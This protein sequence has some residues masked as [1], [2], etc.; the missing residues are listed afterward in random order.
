M[1]GRRPSRRDVRDTIITGTL[2]A[3]PVMGLETVVAHAPG[4]G[5]CASIGMFIGTALSRLVI[6]P[7]LDARRERN[8]PGWVDKPEAPKAETEA[9]RDE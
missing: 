3:A 1:F 7:W 6:S 5:L 4:A 8:K 9:T 2:T